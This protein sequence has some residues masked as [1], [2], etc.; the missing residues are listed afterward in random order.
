[1]ARSQHWLPKHRESVSDFDLRKMFRIHLMKIT[2]R[3]AVILSPVI[4]TSSSLRIKAA[5]VQ[6]NSADILYPIQSKT[7]NVSGMYFVF[8]GVIRGQGIIF[9]CQRFSKILELQLRPILIRRSLSKPRN[10]SRKNNER[11][12]GIRVYSDFYQD[13]KSQFSEIF[14]IQ[15]SVKF[16]VVNFVGFSI[17]V[18]K[19]SL[20]VKWGFYSAG[21]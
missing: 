3:I 15:K 8:V 1:M 2:L 14:V 11:M 19:N 10:K 6:A 18:C 16:L 9:R 13:Q 7:I 17:H 12:S 20:F 5:Y 4:S 21:I